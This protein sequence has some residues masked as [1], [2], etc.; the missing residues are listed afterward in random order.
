MSHKL[1]VVT[2]VD[3]AYNS[4]GVFSLQELMEYSCVDI[5]TVG[6]GYDLED[7]VVIAA[8]HY[9]KAD[10]TAESYRHLFAIPKECIKNIEVLDGE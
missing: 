6:W 7:R 8:E 10:G 5:K 1:M 4:G 3:C 9:F 2:W